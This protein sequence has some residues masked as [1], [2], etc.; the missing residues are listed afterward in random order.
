VP[1]GSGRFTCYSD[2][3]GQFGKIACGCGVPYGGANCQIGCPA[4]D[5]FRS[6]P[7]VNM[8]QRGYWLCGRPM[9]S[10]GAIL[11]GGG[12]V[13]R[14]GISVAPTSGTLSGGNYTLRAE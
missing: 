11:S 14:G 7:Y 8:S 5:L 1:E 2:A 12:Y 9:A 10:D 13:L 6:E 3:A 4:S